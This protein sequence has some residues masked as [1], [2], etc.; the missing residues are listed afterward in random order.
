MNSDLIRINKL[1]LASELAHHKLCDN[2][3]ESIQIYVDEKASVTN[4]TDVA[5][6]IF[7]QYYDQYLS[8]IECCEQ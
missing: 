3:R 6:D 4:Y 7:N 8:L 2:W 5:Q 1:E